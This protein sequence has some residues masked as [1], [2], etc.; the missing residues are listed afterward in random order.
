MINRTEAI[1]DT[2][3]TIKYNI[4]WAKNVWGDGA[5]TKIYDEIQKQIIEE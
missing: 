2:S 1:Q 5:V 4:E 3:E